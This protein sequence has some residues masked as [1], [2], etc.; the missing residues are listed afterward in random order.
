MRRRRDKGAG[1][2][3]SS[4]RKEGFAYK[5]GAL[6]ICFVAS[7][8]EAKRLKSGPKPRSRRLETKRACIDA[9]FELHVDAP[10]TYLCKS[11]NPQT[12]QSSAPVAILG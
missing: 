9:S 5:C 7:L 1:K 6:Y 3:T 4:W 10:R 8:V 11:L 12:L 2:E